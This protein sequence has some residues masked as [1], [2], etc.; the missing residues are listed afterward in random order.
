MLNLAYFRYSD[1]VWFEF[2]EKKDIT[3][4]LEFLNFSR[5]V[6]RSKDPYSGV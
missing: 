5:R 2:E 1:E 4:V 3:K 6:F